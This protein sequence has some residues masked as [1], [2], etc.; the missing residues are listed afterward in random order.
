M[1]KADENNPTFA[2]LRFDAEQKGVKNA[3]KLRKLDLQHYLNGQML[4]SKAQL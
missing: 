1:T 3:A 2:Q 4:K